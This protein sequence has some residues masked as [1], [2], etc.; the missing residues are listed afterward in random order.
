VYNNFLKSTSIY[1]EFV[2]GNEPANTIEGVV[3][4]RGLVKKCDDTCVWKEGENLEYT[5]SSTYKI[6]DNLSSGE[7]KLLYE[8]FWKVKAR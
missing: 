3:D 4:G 8:S 1:Q 2:Y 6:C 5:I 7:Y